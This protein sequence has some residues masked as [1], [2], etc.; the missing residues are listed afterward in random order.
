MIPSSISI[1]LEDTLFLF[2]RIIINITKAR[3][4]IPTIKQNTII[5]VL[6]LLLLLLF[7]SLFELG[8]MTLTGGAS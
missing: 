5:R 2:I 4:I 1:S 3:R 6:L 7:L 8:R